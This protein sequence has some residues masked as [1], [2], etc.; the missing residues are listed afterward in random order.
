MMVN[1]ARSMNFNILPPPPF[2]EL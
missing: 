2:F 1:E